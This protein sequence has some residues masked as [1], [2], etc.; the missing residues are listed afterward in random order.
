MCNN[1]NKSYS[2]I[3]L[4]IKQKK[5][6]YIIIVSD[7]ITIIL[8]KLNVSV[9]VTTIYESLISHKEMT[10]IGLSRKFNFKTFL[11]CFRLN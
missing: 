5:T 10:F 8:R 2:V 3:E 11:K 7:I 9:D 6:N 4:N 1:C